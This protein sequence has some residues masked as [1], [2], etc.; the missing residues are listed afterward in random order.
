M[1][2]KETLKKMDIQMNKLYPVLFNF[3]TY[4][5]CHQLP[6]RSF[7]IKSYQF[8]VCARCT[9]VLIGYI[10]CPILHFVLGTNLIICILGCLIMFIDWF[11]QYLDIKE[12][13]NVRRL[14]T[15]ILGGYGVL[16]TQLL[17]LKSIIG[18]VYSFISVYF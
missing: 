3:G 2:K 12:S 15:G 11:I 4:A 5:G 14:I 8:P 9:G 7:F 16:G 18:F 1:K 6:E 10:L 13:T 17:C